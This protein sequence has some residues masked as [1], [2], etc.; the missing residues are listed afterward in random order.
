MKKSTLAI[1]GVLGLGAYLYIKNRKTKSLTMTDVN[2][3][4]SDI[5][6]TVNNAT[7]TP[8]SNEPTQ[9]LVEDLPMPTG[10]SAIVDI[11]TTTP[12]VSTPTA[13][14]PAPVNNYFSYTYG[15]A[16]SGCTIYW[17]NKDGSKGSAF[18][19]AGDYYN[20]PCMLE[21]SGSGCGAWTKGSAC[22]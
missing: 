19:N 10:I 3:A 1:I 15:K 22:N 7:S 16:M 20:V 11:P 6:N 2:S 8:D 14:A 13:S 9:V 17:T 5:S 21:N 4:V 12:I 18:V